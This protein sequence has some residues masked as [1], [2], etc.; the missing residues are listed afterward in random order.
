MLAV[1]SPLM[2]ADLSAPLCMPPTPLMPKVQL[3]ELCGE[4]AD[5]KDVRIMTREE[6]LVRK[7]DMMD[8][9]SFEDRVPA[10]SCGEAL[11][12]EVTSLRFVAAQELSQNV[13]LLLTLFVAQS[14]TSALRESMTSLTTGF[15]H[16]LLSYWKDGRLRPFWQLHLSQRSVLLLRHGIPGSC[17]AIVWHLLLWA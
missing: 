11:G 2:V 8:E 12:L 15:L 3:P 9:P 14:S 10:K 16:G 13:L 6:S 5:G 1:L 4:Q 17:T 7:L